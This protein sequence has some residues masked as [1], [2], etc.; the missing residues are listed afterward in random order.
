MYN[1]SMQA[2]KWFLKMGLFCIAIWINSACLIHATPYRTVATG[3]LASYTQTG[4]IDEDDTAT[5]ASLGFTINF[6]GTNQTRLYI[7][8]NATIGSVGYREYTATDL[9]IY[10][11]LAL[12][13]VFHADWDSRFGNPITYGTATIDGK[14]AFVVN[15]DNVRQY[16]NTKTNTVQLVI[17]DRSDTGAGNF[18]AEY[19]YTNITWDSGKAFIGYLSGLSDN[20]KWKFSGSL[21]SGAFF[22]TGPVPLIRVRTT[23]GH[24][25]GRILLQSRGGIMT[26]PNSTLLPAIYSPIL[27]G[28]NTSTSYDTFSLP[29]IDTSIIVSKDGYEPVFGDSFQIL[30]NVNGGSAS[31]MT[32]PTLGVGLCWDLTTLFSDGKIKI[33]KSPISLY[34]PNVWLD[35]S[36]TGSL[37]TSNTNVIKWYDKTGN[38]NHATQSTSASQP[39]YVT[40]VVNSKPVLRFDGANDCLSFATQLFAGSGAR[41][42]IAVIKRNNANSAPIY[43]DN[44]GG[45]QA[46]GFDSDTVW[47][48]A[49]SGQGFTDLASSSAFRVVMVSIDTGQPISKFTINS[50]GVNLRSGDSFGA[51]LNTSSSGT[52]SIGR[53]TSGFSFLNGDIAEILMYQRKLKPWEIDKITRYYRTK[54][55]IP[56]TETT[57]HP[58]LF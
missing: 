14:N 34:T 12:L 42:I 11:N 31:G 53:T 51:A 24:P 5:L 54:Y 13:A 9:T 17:I 19:N 35:A 50:K 2:K 47:Y 57:F 48:T 10:N 55:K 45:A 36:D 25:V 26:P 18:D 49:N 40:N 38:N 28:P 43:A 21:A 56:G 30:N 8:S 7:N 23:G 16:S 37:N 4:F 58:L 41:T 52:S 20:T 44:T 29:L 15:W 39:T 46:F 32:L 3:G 6:F 27:S 1:K 22:N 33:I